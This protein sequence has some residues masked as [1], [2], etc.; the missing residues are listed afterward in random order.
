MVISEI[1]N[2]GWSNRNW[3]ETSMKDCE[4]KNQNENGTKIKEPG[5]WASRRSERRFEFPA[6]KMKYNKAQSSI[7]MHLVV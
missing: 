5:E 3:V 2:V 6:G 1:E 4:E 7:D